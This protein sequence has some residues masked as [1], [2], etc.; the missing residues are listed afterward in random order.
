M[1]KQA[2]HML[3]NFQEPTTPLTVAIDIT[4]RCNSKCVYCEVWKKEDFSRDLTPEDIDR[5]VDQA[6]EA[7]VRSIVLSGGEVTAYKDLFRL[8]GDLR[9]RGFNVTLLTNGLLFKPGVS[10][11][12]VDVINNCVDTLQL[13]LDSPDAKRYEDLRGVPG[14]DRVA[15]ALDLI[16][17]P[18]RGLSCVVSSE[19]FWELDAIVRFAA[20]HHVD[21]VSF[22][23]LSVA[24]VFFDIPVL[25]GKS[26]YLPT[27]EMFES[28]HR[29][30]E[31]AIALARELGVRTNLE[32]L[33]M[34]IEPF[35]KYSKTEEKDYFFN[36]V[37]GLNNFRCVF[38]SQAVYINAEGEMTPCRLLPSVG[39]VKGKNFIEEWRTNP[40][41]NEIRKNLK[42]GQYYEECK[43]CYCQFPPNMIYSLMAD[44]ISNYQLLKH[45]LPDAMWRA[46][47]LV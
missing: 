35:F 3:K 46:R 31:S 16:T 39:N 7:G 8:L 9:K 6:D 18:K 30:L 36:H 47:K 10:Q 19:N 23:P 26:K 45:V 24:T 21:L 28:L 41:L 20:E 11:E 42:Q 34:W 27:A 29:A 5:I 4:S 33:V 13:S 43:T 12:K 40:G 22:Q 32:Q 17:K 14:V 15:R 44:P 38:P 25:K 1:L 2:W 37:P